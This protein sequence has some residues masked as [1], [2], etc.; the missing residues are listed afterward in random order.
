MAG[1]ADE[2]P[3][4][5]VLD[6]GIGIIGGV[7]IDIECPDRL[8]ETEQ[9]VDLDIVAVVVSDVGS[10]HP[11]IEARFMTKRD[12]RLESGILVAQ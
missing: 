4:V 10:P 9:Q 8:G 11:G 3:I 1:R 5:D 12:A 2:L 6:A 7:D